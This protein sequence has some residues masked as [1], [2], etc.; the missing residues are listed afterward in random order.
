MIKRTHVRKIFRDV[1][2][3][4][5]RSALVISSVFISVLGV[6]AL[7]TMGDLIIR[8]LKQ[9]VKPEAI[10]MI[11]I[12]VAL[13]SGAG[14]DNAAVL[15]LLNNR[16]DLPGLEGLTIAEGKGNFSASFEN[17]VTNDIEEG[18]LRSYSSPLNAMQIEPIRLVEGDW[19]VEG[20]Q[21]LAV[22]TRFADNYG[23]ETG[24]QIS[25][26]IGEN[27]ATYTI[28]GLVFDPYSYKQ[29]KD[30]GSVSPGPIDGIYM[31]FGD[32]STLLGTPGYSNFVIRY[33][34]FQQ[35]EQQFDAIQQLLR[36]ETPYLPK[37]SFIEDPEENGQIILAETFSS[38]LGL[39]AIIAMIVSGFLVINVVNTIV[40]E[41]KRQIGMMKAIGASQM[42]NFII[43]GGIALAY[44]FIGT[45]LAIIPSILVGYQ[46]SAILA[47]QLDVLIEGFSW[48]P[49]SVATGT[50]LGIIIPVIAALVPVYNGT[51]VTIIEA[52]TDLGIDSRYGT[53][54]VSRFIGDLPLPTLIRQGLSNVYQKKGRLTLTGL[55]LT[56]AIGA[57]M[58]VVAMAISLSNGVADVFDRIN[59]QITIFPTDL[60]DT[61]TAEQIALSTD[62]VVA[63]HPAVVLSV[64]IDADY[65]NFFTRSNQ[66][67]S[68]GI[69]PRNL[70][71]NFHLD[72]GTGW[73][74]DFERQGVTITAPMAKQLDVHIGDELAI[75]INGQ[76]I[77]REIIAI[78]DSAFDFL[79]LL[80]PELAELGGYFSEGPQPNTYTEFVS[81]DGLTGLSVAIGINEAGA[82]FVAEQT[83]APNSI[84]IT[85]A[86]AT[87]GGYQFGDTVNIT[88]KGNTVER[89]ISDIIPQTDFDQL[90]QDQGQ[91]APV[92]NAFFF[93]FNDLV[94]VSGTALGQ[95]PIPNGMFIV[96]DL[97]EP[98][99]DDVEAIIDDLKGNYAEQGISAEF[100][101]QIARSEDVTALIVQ[102]TAILSMA[103]VLI[104]MVGAVGLL[105]TLTINVLERQKEIGVMRSIGASSYTIASQFLTEGLLVGILAW[106]VGIPISYF[107]AIQINAAFR[108]ETIEFKYPIEVMVFGFLVMV[109]ITTI[110]SLGPALSAARKTVSEILRYQ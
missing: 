83:L 82:Q 19:P 26:I 72:E 91:T 41:Q 81:A 18:Q 3:R 50:I 78:D 87:A 64:Q 12:Q 79:W 48:S 98:T 14:V 58:G 105:T 7:L 40:I 95:T 49:R 33:D 90:M 46:F 52:M 42:D 61:E 108:L 31:E 6:I 51:R 96:T 107:V 94:A 37:Y 44:G 65:E 92:Q 89:T 101:N 57:S 63:T 103:A 54:P 71:Y 76:P 59:Y 68:F 93:D 4:K 102:Y 69:D 5:S 24:D 43:Y 55:T 80:W 17:P 35:A 99:A 8:Q 9:D 67:I 104:G 84:F 110:A 38:V 75:I 32:V 11:D 34:S 29:A 62:H 53:G 47:P 70:M 23:F 109:G 45:T 86:A 88:I 77:R 27:R 74:E 10:A 56:S 66:V 28:T 30:D 60:Q 106:V 73:S 36:T 15:D 16:D 1:W 100:Q 22:E 85:E 13:R 21:Q 2:A 97:D 25:L 20:Q 39:L